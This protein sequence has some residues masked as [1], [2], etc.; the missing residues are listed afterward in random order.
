MNRMFGMTM[1]RMW[2]NAPSKYQPYHNHHSQNVLAQVEGFFANVYWVEDDAL[3]SM[4]VPRS[5]LS[6]GWTKGGRC[7][8]TCSASQ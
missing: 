5:A 6:H 1:K 7:L 4:V 3:I 2:V 8:V